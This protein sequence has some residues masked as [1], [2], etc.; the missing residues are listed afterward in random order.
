M[1]LDWF[2]I[3]AQVVNFLILGWLLKRFLYHP[4]LNAIDAREKLIA[5]K[6]ADAETKEV[7]AK[8]ERDAFQEKNREF[9][10]ER[11]ALMSQVS[12]DA[13]EERHRLLTEARHEAT[14]LRTK[15]TEALENERHNLNRQISDRA[16]HE[17]FEIAR[18]TLADLAD[19][20]LEASMV[21]VFLK[22]LQTLPEPEKATL[23]SVLSAPDQPVKVRTMFELTP[24]QQTLIKNALDEIQVSSGR[25]EFSTTP[26]LVSGIELT[27]SGHKIAWSIAD[28]LT[29][30]EESV[31]ALL[32][33]LSP[34]STETKA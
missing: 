26:D 29:S 28:Y 7:E 24:E 12:V 20:P 17:V 8:R 11:T 30:L 9:D 33:D 5:T 18:K 6:L 31:E 25:I 14:L 10:H 23:V 27:A 3:S 4:I 2:T 32:Q 13:K 1:Q 22:R 16:R 15:L 34:T 21:T 19:A